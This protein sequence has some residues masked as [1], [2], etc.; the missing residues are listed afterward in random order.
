MEPGPHSLPGFNSL[1]DIR[2][3]FEREM[4]GPD[5]VSFPDNRPTRFVIDVGDPSPFCA[6]DLPEALLRTLAAVG[7]EATTEGQALITAMAERATTIHLA[8]TGGGK[9]VFPHIHAH[10]NG[11]G[12]VHRLRVRDLND[13]IE[14]P[15]AVATDQFGFFGKAHREELLLMLSGGHLDGHAP[16]ERIQRK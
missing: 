5:M 16:G 12:R 10:H 7:L 4:R 6:G 11:H 14:I 13:E 3:V 1:S 15:L 2:Q 8:G 9:I